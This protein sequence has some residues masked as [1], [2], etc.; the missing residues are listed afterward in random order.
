MT[1]SEVSLSIGNWYTFVDLLVDV[2]EMNI[3]DVHCRHI[4]FGGSTD[5]GYVRQ[6]IPH[7]MDEHVC[8][9]I[10]LLEGPKFEKGFADLVR[11]VR[12]HRFDSVFRTEKLDTT[13]RKVSF[14]RT[15]PR[16]P[17]PAPKSPLPVAGPPVSVLKRAETQ[18]Y[19]STVVAG[20]SS[21]FRVNSI[22]SQPT[23]PMNGVLR[24]THGQRI[25]PPLKYS[26]TLVSELKPRKFCNRFHLLGECPYEPCSHKHGPKLGCEQLNALRH[27]ARQTP[28]A[29]GLECDD[30][31]CLSGH[32]CP[33]T[34]CT[35]GRECKFPREMHGIE[36]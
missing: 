9:R 24:N 33:A 1:R 16:S 10:T 12:T 20:G 31:K 4:L 13:S 29:L 5:T 8:K 36:K 25:D 15:P 14:S 23:L 2:F 17:G 26:T 19:A 21:G 3:N 27:V 6:L 34:P 7:A 30:G 32:S 28:C 22:A 35:W 18:S 11:R